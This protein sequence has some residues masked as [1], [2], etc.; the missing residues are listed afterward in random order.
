MLF[1]LVL[2]KRLVG[3]IISPGEGSDVHP[4]PAWQDNLFARFLFAEAKW[5]GHH[6]LP[7]GLTVVAVG[8]KQ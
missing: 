4:N 1:L 8:K 7:F 3:K 5:L 6:A 2:G